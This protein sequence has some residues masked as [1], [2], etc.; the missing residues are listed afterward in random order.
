MDKS[1]EIYQIVDNS[2]KLATCLNL[3]LTK[4]Y[5]DIMNFMNSLYNS[6]Y[7][8]RAYVECR[9]FFYKPTRFLNMF[10]LVCIE[11]PIVASILKDN[12]NEA[13]NKIYNY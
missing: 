5:G 6:D 9:R 2:Q 4:C 7:K 13:Q 3:I 1:Y 12:I 10:D 8:V 11:L